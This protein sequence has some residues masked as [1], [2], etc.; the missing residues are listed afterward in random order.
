MKGENLHRFH[1]VRIVFLNFVELQAHASKI[2]LSCHQRH[3]LELPYLWGIFWI[4]LQ[5]PKM[6]NSIQKL[7]FV[8]INGE[9]VF[10]RETVRNIWVKRIVTILRKY[11]DSCICF[12]F[13]NIYLYPTFWTSYKLSSFSKTLMIIWKKEKVFAY[14]FSIAGLDLSFLSC[15][16]GHLSIEPSNFWIFDPDMRTYNNVNWSTLHIWKKKKL[17]SEIITFALFL[18]INNTLKLLLKRHIYEKYTHPCKQATEIMQRAS[19]VYFEI[20]SSFQ[21]KITSL[22][23]IL[24]FAYYNSSLHRR[25]ESSTNSTLKFS[26]CSISMETRFVWTCF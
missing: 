8:E 1:W 15:N 4:I 2:A 20:V 25:E 22:I 16:L 7:I 10:L 6:P 14:F 23:T 5:Q 24:L 12:L 13:K 26:I 11:R 3:Q 17:N 19:G 21:S 18:K 9:A